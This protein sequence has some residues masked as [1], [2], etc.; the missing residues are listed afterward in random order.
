MV[1][2]YVK[3]TNGDDLMKKLI[4]V[5]GFSLIF[6][7]YYAT[8]YSGNLMRNSKGM[9]TN[10]LFGFANMMQ[11]LMKEDFT[12]FLVAFD[13]GK[14]TFRHDEYPAYKEGRSKTPSEL[15]EQIPYAKEYVDKLGIKRYE[16]VYY[17]EDDII[18]TLEKKACAKGLRQIL[19][20]HTNRIF[21]VFM[22]MFKNPK[23]VELLVDQIIRCR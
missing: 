20:V 10:C 2:I 23:M 22:S 19:P 9:P 5:D 3:I 16:K 13:A 1:L 8:A 18:G 6:R 7:A 21:A 15:I 14:K 4:L 11:R 17:E 12:H